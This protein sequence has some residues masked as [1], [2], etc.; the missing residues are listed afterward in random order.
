M[1]LYRLSLILIV[2]IWG[3]SLYMWQMNDAARWEMGVY[4]YY[5]STFFEVPLLAFVLGTILVIRRKYCASKALRIWTLSLC[6]LYAF[7][8][9]I[10]SV[11][12]IL[13]TVLGITGY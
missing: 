4:D 11:L 13:I 12:L 5:M 6:W 7:F 3:V 2:T 1:V 10:T 8:P 9:L